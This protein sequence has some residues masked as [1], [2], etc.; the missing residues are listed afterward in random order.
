MYFENNSQ[1]LI[2]QKIKHYVKPLDSW[3]PC[4][5]GTEDEFNKNRSKY[6]K[7]TFRDL[8]HYNVFGGYSKSSAMFD[9]MQQELRP[10]NKEE[11]GVSA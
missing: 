2:F 7:R 3:G 10:L 11:N 4:E 8:F 1:T 6:T 9:I 5:D